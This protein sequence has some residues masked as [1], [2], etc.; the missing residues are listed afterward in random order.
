MT[1][2][3]GPAGACAG[4]AALLGRGTAFGAMLLGRGTASGNGRH[5]LVIRNCLSD[6]RE[7]CLLLPRLV[8]LPLP[9]V[10]Q[11]LPL[12]RRRGFLLLGGRV[13]V[14]A[15][16]LGRTGSVMPL[17]LPTYKL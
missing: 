10:F 6:G 17:A 15:V 3:V 4:D 13:S 7:G 16:N 9:L 11:L 1:A 2:A 5:R 14:A 12:L 8:L